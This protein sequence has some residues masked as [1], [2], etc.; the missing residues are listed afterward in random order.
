MSR[1][2]A[3]SLASLVLL[4]SGC[5]G[6]GGGGGGSSGAPAPLSTPTV[7]F[8]SDASTVVEGGAVAIEVE[9]R[10][11]GAQG[12]A[13]AVTV[14]IQT[15]G[16]AMLGQDYDLPPSVTFAAGSTSGR[17]RTLSFTS[18]SDG[19]VEGPESAVLALVAGSGVQLGPIRRHTLDL[20]DGSGAPTI[21]FA[22]GTSAVGE[23]A[24]THTVSVA[25]ST[26]GGTLTQPLSVSVSRAGGTAT[27]G[28]DLQPL[29]TTS[30]DFPAG[31]SDGAIATVSLQMLQ[32]TLVEPSETVDLVLTG[33]AAAGQTT[34]TVTL[35]DDETASVAFA[36]A[37]SATSNEGGSHLVT[38]TLTSTG[39]LAAPL[40][41]TAT[42]NDGTAN[43][44]SDYTAVS[45]TVSF[46]AGAADGATQ[47]VAVP[48]LGDATVESDETLTLTLSAVAPPA[49]LGLQASHDVTI[50]DDDTVLVSFA[51]ASSATADETA[52]FAVTVRL[53]TTG[54]KTLA[55][56]LTVDATSADGTATAGQDYAAVST[57]VTFPVGAGDGATQT[58]SVTLRADTL[59]EGSEVLT[60]TLS[61]PS[62]GALGPQPTHALAITDDQSA[63]VGF[64]L[65]SST[66]SEGVSSAGVVVRLTTTGGGTL[67]APLSVSAASASGSAVA[68]SDYF[69]VVTVVTFAAGATSGSLQT[70]SVPFV[71]DTL[72]EAGE[73]LTL[74]LSGATGP[75][76]VGASSTHTVTIQ[77][78]ELC[79][80]SFASAASATGD[81]AV[82]GHPVVV[83][84]TG[85]GTL[86]VDLTVT[87]SA[88]G[89]TATSGTDYTPMSTVVTFPAGSSSSATAVVTLETLGDIATEG[90]ET[91]T[92]TLSNPSS[93]GVL[94]APTTHVV[95]ITDDDNVV[96]FASAQTV[97]ADE[98]S[99]P[100]PV[101]LV[102]LTGGGTLGA[103]VTL[104]VSSAD[105]SATAATDYVAVASALVTFPAGSGDRTVRTVDVTV[106][107][108][109]AREG[110][111]TLTL[112]LS[113]V[114]GPGAAGSRTTTTV[115]ITE[116]DL[117][118]LPAN[119]GLEGGICTALAIDPTA[120]STVWAAGRDAHGN[121]AY[122]S[123]DGGS[124]W[125]PRGVGLG[126][127]AVFCLDPTDP[128]VLHAGAGAD[129]F[130]SSDGGATW[131]TITPSDF[132]TSNVVRALARHPSA[133]ATLLVG[134]NTI[135]RTTNGGVT[136]ALSVVPGGLVVAALAFDPLTPSTA[137]AATSSGVL[138]SIDGG[139][140]WAQ[141]STGITTQSVHDIVVDPAAP[142]TLYAATWGGGVFKSTDGGAT[143][144]AT[145]SGVNS[146]V[147]D[148]AFA[149]GA[150]TTIYAG[151]A[152]GVFRSTNAGASWSRLG[153]G[154]TGGVDDLAIDP[155]TP[156]TLFAATT[157]GVARSTDGG[158]TWSFVNSGIHSQQMSVIAAD[159]TVPT[160]V[161]CAPLRGLLKSTDGGATWSTADSGLTGNGR[162][163]LSIAVDPVTSGRVYLGTSAG[164]HRS[165]DGGGTWSA[166]PSTPLARHLVVDPVTPS[167]L[168]CG[169]GSGVFC[170]ADSGA[171]W[172]TVNSG[173]GSLDVVSLAIDPSAP[174]TLYAGTSIAGAF[175]TTT[176]GAS[177][178]AINT[179]LTGTFVVLAIDP[180]TPTT[181][182]AGTSNGIGNVFRSVNGGASWSVASSGLISR[183]PGVFAVSPSSTGTV[184]LSYAGRVY[185]STDAASTWS[186]AENGLA[187]LSVGRLAVDP[188][189]PAI[190]YASTLNGG[191]YKTTTGGQ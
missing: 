56:P 78:N 37:T 104:R 177:W 130:R 11:P 158:T 138:K 162:F 117:S 146:L 109:A 84:R 12:L 60:L 8:V 31:A 28:S 2:G 173:L 22:S 7:S 184:Y 1:R 42:S 165:T 111:E 21:A 62:V 96:S 166:L 119:A 23:A 6:G 191:V 168:Y 33:G 164:I 151:T 16:S 59:V 190:V 91:L 169:N 26:G 161:Y 69:D 167:R 176:A 57:V 108:D 150:S 36:S 157:D 10:L 152:V 133:P 47:T 137:Y 94:I 155:T 144:S 86:A 153:S 4:I 41:L 136:W 81:E 29:G 85:S 75:G 87:V 149:P 98:S 181:L 131:A 44:G 64:V 147:D 66:T 122:R 124:T 93:P 105:G 50:I 13:Q 99:G 82:A 65:A 45:T 118:W 70:V 67:A 180:G 183:G 142:A 101:E 61:N 5:G 80:V 24:G 120:T 27:D 95:T 154:L 76:A 178:S 38:V 53:T 3:G 40:D 77:D 71:N 125:L 114:S 90:D 88:G 54:G 49:T 73:T 46:P 189:D 15:S 55:A 14:T 179:G 43:A 123:T 163:V 128:A 145:G 156:T 25:L 106:L 72:C 100:H 135:R 112:T 20:Q 19:L 92:L 83:Q 110:D 127:V 116:D 113:S 132:N 68:G 58:I 126:G 63:S 148:L 17:R 89:G 141:S 79:R 139:C 121:G 129:V 170:S 32:D 185:R 18:R 52:T 74:T 39:T 175:K 34:H 188:S 48:V 182:Y 186:L 187:G 97:T 9:L 35:Q 107:P 102:L 103:D 30:A 174:A 172:T 160:T 143:W 134:Q 140:T 51:A 115:R 159:P 171:T